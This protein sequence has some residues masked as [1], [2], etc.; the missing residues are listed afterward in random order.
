MEKDSFKTK[1]N[2]I[3][4]YE[5]SNVYLKLSIPVNYHENNDIKIVIL[6]LLFYRIELNSKKLILYNEIEE[7]IENSDD[8]EILFTIMEF[9]RE[10]NVSRKLTEK[11]H[12]KENNNGNED[13]SKNCNEKISDCAQINF[14]AESQTN[15]TFENHENSCDVEN[16][17]DENYETNEGYDEMNFDYDEKNNH[18]CEKYKCKLKNSDKT[19]SNYSDEK[20][21]SLSKNKLE[22][23]EN[24]KIF[25]GSPSFE[26]K[27][28][29]LSHFAYVTSM[30]EVYEFRNIIV[31]DKKYSRATH[32][33]FAYRFTC[34][35][36]GEFP[37]YFYRL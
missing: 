13:I 3:L 5:D 25:H 21:K 28:Q 35:K 15:S 31:N 1:Y 17:N 30:D 8:G 6:N 20:N 12:G 29:F 9:I 7:I 26:K 32:N 4:V 10:Q 19:N 24:L 27:S 36:T 18:D 22:N 33:I 37:Y 23:L 11:E 2:K 34:P 14:P 16:E